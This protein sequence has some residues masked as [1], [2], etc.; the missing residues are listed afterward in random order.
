MARFV[1]STYPEVGPQ[2]RIVNTAP[3]KN[4]ILFPPDDVTPA[5]RSDDNPYPK[6]GKDPGPM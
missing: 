4:R 2:E 5:P 3:V 6:H 1:T